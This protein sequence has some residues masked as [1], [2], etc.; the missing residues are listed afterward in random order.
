MNKIEFKLRKQ[1]AVRSRKVTT[2]G[3]TYCIWQRRIVIL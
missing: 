2:L 3:M 1:E